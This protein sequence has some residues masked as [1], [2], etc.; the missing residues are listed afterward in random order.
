MDIIQLPNEINDIIIDY[1]SIYDE[2]LN[3]VKNYRK[4]SML[5]YLQ[6]IKDKGDNCNWQLLLNTASYYGHIEL[7]QFIIDD[8][9]DSELD[10]NDSMTHAAEGGHSDLIIYFKD[11]HSYEYEDYTDVIKV[12]IQNHGK[13]TANEITKLLNYIY[14]S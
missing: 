6:L 13:Y 10:Y 3:A 8:N 11:N 5:F 14:K 1:V 12:I 9:D 4:E 2:L 7:V